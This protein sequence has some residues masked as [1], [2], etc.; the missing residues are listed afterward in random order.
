MFRNF[1]TRIAYL[2]SCEG[3][4]LTNFVE[5]K[6]GRFLGASE[7]VPAVIQPPGKRRNLASSNISCEIWPIKCFLEGKKGIMIF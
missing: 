4:E 2:F 6:S 1:L 3:N 7:G 5:A